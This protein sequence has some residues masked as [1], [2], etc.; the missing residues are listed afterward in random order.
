[1]KCFFFYALRQLLVLHQSCK[2]YILRETT[3]RNST[4][5]HMYGEALV[6]AFCIY[7]HRTSRAEPALGT[8]NIWTSACTQFDVS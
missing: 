3:C 5:A 2:Q 4:I 1:M 6:V 7:F 8:N